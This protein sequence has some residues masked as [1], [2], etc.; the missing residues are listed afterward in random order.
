MDILITFW[1]FLAANIVPAILM[2]VILSIYFMSKK[3]R[4]YMIPVFVLAMSLLFNTD[5]EPVQR[6]LATSEAA[7][8]GDAENVIEADHSAAARVAPILN[9]FALDF[10][11]SRTWLGYGTDVA[12]ADGHLNEMHTVWTDWGVIAYFI[13]LILIFSCGWSSN[14]GGVQLSAA[15]K[16]RGRR[17]ARA[18]CSSV[19]LKDTR[20]NFINCQRVP[21]P[22]RVSSFLNKDIPD[23]FRTLRFSSDDY[24]IQGL[25]PR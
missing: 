5:Y 12:L 3:Q 7:L 17:L 19:M 4:L 14:N 13:G 1:S 25:Q 15:S 9:A 24:R 18:S 6:A 2:L 16:I 20:L 21:S 22:N 8:T 23:F 10:G 11:D